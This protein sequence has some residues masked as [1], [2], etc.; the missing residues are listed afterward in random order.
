MCP[1]T[2]IN[3]S[4]FSHPPF[5]LFHQATCGSWS[6]KK[7]RAVH[8]FCIYISGSTFINRS[9]WPKV[10]TRITS[11]TSPGKIDQGLGG[12][13]GG[14]LNDL[15]LKKKKQ[16]QNMVTEKVERFG[17]WMYKKS[18]RKWIHLA[19]SKGLW[20]QTSKTGIHLGTLAFTPLTT[21][22][23]SGQ[24]PRSSLQDCHLICH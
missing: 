7:T 1:S 22:K 3:M 9:N 17:S 12:M 24:L 14:L 21:E 5:P 6:I 4:F 18:K 11:L 10:Y 8:L 20:Y 23:F 19:S 16:V 2:T 15:C 13:K